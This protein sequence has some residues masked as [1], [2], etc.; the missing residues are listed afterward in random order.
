MNKQQEYLLSMLTEIHEI[1]QK[2]DITYYLC[3]GSLIGSVRGGGFLPW[4]DDADVMMTYDNW[5]KFKEACKT[6]LPPNRALGAP[7]LF[8]SYPLLLPRYIA[9]DTTSIHTAQSLHD[10]VAG[11][12]IDIFI[13]DPIADGDEAY[14]GWLENVLCLHETVNYANSN[15]FRM[16]L[17]WEKAKEYID[18]RQEKGKLA[19]VE[20]LQE[21]I[22]SYHDPD[23]SCYAFRWQGCP[24]L[25]QRS[26]FEEAVP[27]QFEGR[28]FFIPKGTNEYLMNWF[29]EE[30]ADIPPNITPARHNTAATLDVPYDQALEFYRPTFDRQQL[31][32]EMAERKR[33][34]L[35]TGPATNRLVAD[36]FAARCEIVRART[37]RTLEEHKAEF[38]Q[39]LAEKNG[40][41]LRGLLADFIAQQTSPAAIGRHD[42]QYMRAY[43]HPIIMETSEEIFRAALYAL[44]ETECIRHAVR[45]LQVYDQAGKPTSPGV[46]EIRRGIDLFH[47][48]TD[49]YQYGQFEQGESLARQALELFP[50]VSGYQKLL[51]AFLQRTAEAEQTDDAWAALESYVDQRLAERPQDGYYVKLKADCLARTQGVDAVLMMYLEAAESTQ[52]GFT[53]KSIKEK[54]GYDPSWLRLSWWGKRFGIPE[55]EGP[56]PQNM[57]RV[58]KEL[59]DEE[60]L[61]L[62]MQ[63]EADADFATDK[64]YLFDLL[65]QLTDIC[66][67]NG[68]PY[69]LSKRTSQCFFAH[70]RLPAFPW[71]AT[72]LVAP[73]DALRLAE[74]L[75]ANPPKDR[76]LEYMGN[77]PFVGVRELRFCGMDSTLGHLEY[78]WPTKFNYQYVSVRPLEPK[79]Y[80]W[81][82][83][84]KLQQW[85]DASALRGSVKPQDEDRARAFFMDPKTPERG[86]KLFAKAMRQAS[87]KNCAFV[88][89]STTRSL[90]PRYFRE[91]RVRR[92]FRDHEFSVS[93]NLDEYIR[94]VGPGP[95]P[96]KSL[97]LQRNQVVAADVPAASLFDSGVVPQGYFDDRRAVSAVKKE[98]SQYYSNF[99]RNFKE[100]QLAVRLKEVSHE[101]LTQKEQIMELAAQGADDELYELVK[102]YYLCLSRYKSFDPEQLVFD[103]DIYDVTAA[104]RERRFKQKRQDIIDAMDLDGSD[105]DEDADE[106]DVAAAGEADA[107]ETESE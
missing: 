48:A 27:V 69:L 38:D 22:A 40:T 89:N 59:E 94:E 34:I 7:E 90:I 99:D 36:V 107:A 28:T 102:R 67:A 73:E 100:L 82:L 85:A 46:D 19:T 45:L 12:V 103:Q 31:R 65:C 68:I 93:A 23:G 13:L 74:L 70:D 61:E 56:L 30:W 76:C 24:I 96:R 32:K 18:M 37:L 39:A 2:H 51:A 35:S 58:D 41:V 84:P 64:R 55:W 62:R 97:G 43:F 26:W 95:K 4:D 6:D 101:L 29:G 53:L 14:R 81:L 91:E 10:D 11:E 16:G 25:F 71:E 66:D 1:C 33:I 83:E 60:S 106:A 42:H 63:D 8:E 21:R 92:A 3:G 5:L 17:E 44:V 104:L 98:A 105:D 78:A 80:S 75:E 49:C 9:T 72:I 52:N 79:E 88:R 47:Q 54:T 86:R 50:R 20:H 15:S 57:Q 87:K 77:S